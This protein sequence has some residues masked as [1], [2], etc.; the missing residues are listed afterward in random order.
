MPLRGWFRVLR[1]SFL[2]LLSAE[3]VS[4]LAGGLSGT[5]RA[6][7]PNKLKT[8]P[9]QE[10]A[11]VTGAAAGWR[12]SC[13]SSCE[14]LARQWGRRTVLGTLGAQCTPTPHPT[15]GWSFWRCPEKCPEDSGVGGQQGSLGLP[16]WLIYEAGLR[17]RM[18]CPLAKK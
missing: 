13:P 6:I 4:C 18:A 10:K 2:P 9:F 7:D 11:L 12:D 3:A 1:Q 14:P 16:T 5:P 8:S 17:R 15:R